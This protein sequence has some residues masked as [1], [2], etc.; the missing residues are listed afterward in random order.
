MAI[1]YDAFAKNSL[2]NTALHLALLKGD[3]KITQMILQDKRVMFEVT[4]NRGVSILEL[5]AN[6]ERGVTEPS[7]K[8]RR[9]M[10]FSKDTTIESSAPGGPVIRRKP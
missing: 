7:R 1:V 9:E 5:L 4:N 6:R 2:G 3:E 8:T 10:L